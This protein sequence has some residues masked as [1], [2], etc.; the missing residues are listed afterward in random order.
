MENIS[1]AGNSSNTLEFVSKMGV[2][3]VDYFRSTLEAF[4][5]FL[6]QLGTIR[7]TELSL[8]THNSPISEDETI[9]ICN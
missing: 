6:P 3:E 8:F 9:N 7:T 1:A 2:C 4:H 5:A